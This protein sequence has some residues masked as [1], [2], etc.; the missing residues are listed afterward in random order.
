MR[1]ILLLTIAF[2]SVGVTAGLCPISFKE[3]TFISEIGMKPVKKTVTKDDGMTKHQY[4]FRKELS[5]EEAFSD[6]ADKD[7]E[8]Q[9]Y[10]TIYNPSCPKKVK[11][12]FY[13]DNQNTAR[14]SNVLLAGKA[15]GYLTGV[16]GSVFTNKFNKLKFVQQFE[17]FDENTESKF[18]KTGD[19]YSIDVN[20]M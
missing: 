20:L 17:S 15:F 2:W 3:S 6:N 12:W 19:I 18:I 9:F 8:P 1:I 16:G 13:K 11:I 10:V 7:Y 14:H 4:E 5:P